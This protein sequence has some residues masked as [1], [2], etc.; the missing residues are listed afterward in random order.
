MFDFGLNNFR[1]R[2]FNKELIMSLIWRDKMVTKSHIARATELSIPAVSNILEELLTQGLI[3]HSEKNLSKRGLG[4]GSYLIPE[5]HPMTLCLNVTPTTIESQL[6]DHQL[7]AVG[8]IT[9]E[10]I[11]VPTPVVLL[12]EMAQRYIRYQKK[13]PDKKIR[14][15]IAIHGQV[16]PETGV[17]QYMPQAP[18]KTS[19]EVKYILE[20]RLKCPVIV[21]NDC[22][23]L[24]LAEKWQGNNGR[25]DFC[26][27]NV[28]YGIGSSFIINNTIYRGSLHGSGQIGHTIVDPD[29][30]ACSCGRYGCLETIASLSAIK[31][32]VRISLKLKPDLSPE[33]IEHV[34]TAL[35]M[36]LWNQQEPVILKLVEDGANAIGLSLYNFL[37]VLNINQIWLYGTSCQFGQQWLEMITRHVTGNP[38]DPADTIKKNATRIEFGQLTRQQQIMGIAWLYVEES[39][40]AFRAC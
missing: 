38:F 19:I 34:D 22:I 28:D 12:E 40:A 37:N 2:Q 20:E 31:K 11:T 8:E 24:A 35:L 18:W 32:Q 33:D 5:S 10:A 29:G 21:D 17:S 23:M 6:V 14:L 4:S 1:M 39:L 13:F 9:C 3:C 26:V 30:K 36:S 25:K 15:A 7:C 27:I 16:D